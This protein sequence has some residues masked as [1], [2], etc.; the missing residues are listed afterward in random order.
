MESSPTQG[1][2]S[3]LHAE[4]RGQDSGVAV[5]CPLDVLTILEWLKNW[6]FHFREVKYWICQSSDINPP[7]FGKQAFNIT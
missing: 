6:K 7:A 3:P 4:G 1:Y 5:D 2:S